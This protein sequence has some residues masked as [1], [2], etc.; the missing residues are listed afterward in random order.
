MYSACV[1]IWFLQGSCII[2]EDNIICQFKAL[3]VQ[4]V[5]ISSVCPY[6]DVP[7][8]SRDTARCDVLSSFCA[9]LISPIMAKGE[10]AIF[11]VSDDPHGYAVIGGYSQKLVLKM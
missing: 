10:A 11:I 1:E 9:Q 4:C 2:P 8:H 6:V 3:E 5:D 7:H